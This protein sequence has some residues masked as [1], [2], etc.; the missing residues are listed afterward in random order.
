MLLLAL[1]DQG[2]FSVLGRSRPVLHI[3]PLSHIFDPRFVSGLF[4]YFENETSADNI[5][6]V[7]AYFERL[8]GCHEFN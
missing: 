8:L 4:F 3:V 1:S 7:E 6:L 5:G 2:L